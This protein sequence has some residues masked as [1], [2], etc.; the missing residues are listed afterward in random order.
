[1]DETVTLSVTLVHCLATTSQNT[2]PLQRLEKDCS[3]SNQEKWKQV[4]SKMICW[5]CWNS[6]L[7]PFST[8]ILGTKVPDHFSVNLNYFW[9]NPPPRQ[10]AKY[11]SQ[12]ATLFL[13][14]NKPGELTHTGDVNDSQILDILRIC[15]LGFISIYLPSTMQQYQNTKLKYSNHILNERHTYGTITDTMD[16]I[17]VE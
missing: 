4:S 11:F 8:L 6:N 1:M 13:C 10:T 17:K 3:H 12:F 15:S 9:H 7:I 14:S 5:N 16:V 2:F